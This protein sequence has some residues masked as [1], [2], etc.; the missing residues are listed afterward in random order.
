M[1]DMLYNQINPI[2]RI[3]ESKLLK[4]AHFD[5]MLHCQHF[6]EVKNLLQGTPY[7]EYLEAADFDTRFEYYLRK[8]QG[9]LFKKLYSLGPEK[10][11]IDIYSMRYTYHNLKLLTKAAYSK[12]NL[13]AYFL[14]DGLYS[15]ATIKSAIT[16]L[17]SSSVKGLLMESILEV[18]NYL[19]NYDNR[20]AID[21]IYDRF[22][23]KNQRLVANQVNYPDLTKEVIAFIDLTNISMVVRGIRQQRNENFLLASLSSSGSFSKR[24]L[25]EFATKS[26]SEFVEFLLTTDYKSVIEPLID[27]QTQ[28]INLLLLARERDN[29]LTKLYGASHTQAFGP[30]PLLSLLNAK[31]IEIRNIQLI[32]IGKKNQFSETAI[33]ERM[34]ELDGL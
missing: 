25:A 6:S 27:K 11:V 5:K 31:D 7:G 13:D 18:H 4:G 17:A 34:R 14:D 15:L 16:N 29:F 8:E 33:S 19:E 3:E 24:Y 30:L 20:Q 2:V 21:L 9:R 32:L 10:E 23:L 1:K 26:L 22:Y 12:Q 28:H